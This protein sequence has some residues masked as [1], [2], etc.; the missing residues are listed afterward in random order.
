[1]NEKERW[2]ELLAIKLAMETALMRL[3]SLTKEKV[4]E[5]TVTLQIEPEREGVIA[6]PQ[7][8]LCDLKDGYL[9][10]NDDII[11][12][13]WGIAMRTTGPLAEKAFLLNEEYNWVLGRDNELRLC[14]VPI[15][16]ES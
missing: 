12:P 3:D 11:G 15:K 6:I 8:S 14:L 4:E 16:K 10:I 13:C 2:E 9:Y 1:M 5:E 7:T